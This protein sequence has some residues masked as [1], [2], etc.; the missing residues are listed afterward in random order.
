MR[1]CNVFAVADLRIGHLAWCTVIAV[2]LAG[3]GGSDTAGLVVNGTPP[4]SVE[5]GAKYQYTPSVS[6]PDGRP[7]SYDITSKPGWATFV[8]SSGELF[9]TPDNSDV[10]TSAEI[11]IGVSNG[12]TRAI[13]GPF[14]ITVKPPTTPPPF[15]PPTI[16]GT[17]AATVTAGQPYSFQP[18]VTNPGRSTLSFTIVNRPAWGTSAPPRVRCPGRPPP[19]TRAPLPT[20]GSA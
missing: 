13:I 9:G 1:V 19:P 17:P 10:G 18:M 16:T 4:T 12:T 2:T 20:S 7:L 14:R 15:T 11:E 3:C 5:A 8:A 6:N